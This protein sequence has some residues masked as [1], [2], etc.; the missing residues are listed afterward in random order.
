MPEFT[1][2]TNILDPSITTTQTKPLTASDLTALERLSRLYD[3]MRSIT[4]ITELDKLLDRILASATGLLEARG[5]FL[6]LVNPETN[7]LK[8]EVTS[9]GMAAG[10]KGAILKID[11]RTVPGKV[12]SSGKAIRENDITKS[13]FFANQKRNSSGNYAIHK[14]MCVPL[15]VQDRVTGVVQVLDKKEGRDFDQDDLRLLQAMADTAAIA[16]ENVRLY[17]AE[18]KKSEL[19]TKANEELSANYSG[20]LQALTGL[21]DARDTATR[22]HSERVTA[23][24]MRLVQELGIT[25][26]HKIR[27]IRL[28][29]LLHDVGKIGVPDAILRKP[30][31]LDGDDWQQ[32]R[33]HPEIGYRLLKHIEFLKDALPVVRY[34]HER[35]DGTGYPY[36]LEKRQIPLEARIFAVADAFDAIISERP[37]KKA[38]TYE[39]AVEIFKN[40]N[41]HFFDPDVVEAFM[42]VT[43]EEWMQI[44]EEA[45]ETEMA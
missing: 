19:L 35:F 21:L 2:K 20:T 16:V 25:D 6:M 10:L 9:G 28:G 29:A 12:T 40:D 32:M 33:A 45:Q 37:Y 24:T 43:K 18:R 41:G 15:K 13:P 31:A 4:S 39:Q 23:L 5:G 3:I 1:V 11:E 14:L 36:G 26:P 38:R 30:G 34:H 44:L 17:E 8:C 7:E 42:R 27:S 22:G